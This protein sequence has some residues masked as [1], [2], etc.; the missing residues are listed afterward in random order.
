MTE[1]HC[2][3]RFLSM[4]TKELTF[5]HVHV[6]A[7]ILPLHVQGC[8]P[9]ISGMTC[10]HAHPAFPSAAVHSRHGHA[11]LQQE[12]PS[13]MPWSLGDAVVILVSFWYT[14]MTAQH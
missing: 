10:I 14:M 12:G 7:L 9:E 2:P 13:H 4:Q 1:V 11:I 3:V 8:R 5:L 6:K